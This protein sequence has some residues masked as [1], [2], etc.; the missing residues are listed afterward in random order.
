MDPG[1]HI[2]VARAGEIAP[3]DDRVRVAE[4]VI[5]AGMT[6]QVTLHRG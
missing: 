4:S 6:E 2:G 3:R 1:W 5:I